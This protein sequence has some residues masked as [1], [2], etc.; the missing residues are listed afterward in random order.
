[1]I[2]LHPGS[3]TPLVS[4]IVDGFRRLIGEQALRAGTK[5][6][7]IRALAATHSVSVFTVVEAY[8]RLVAD[9]PRVAYLTSR[10]A[11]LNARLKIGL[12]RLGV[13][14]REETIGDYDVFY[15]LSQR[16][17]PDQLGLGEACCDN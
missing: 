11:A 13:S 7:S 9:S 6:P 17:T 1:M 16:V 5:L 12:A 8:D 2:T 14:Y 15:A 10:N 3:S 4:Q